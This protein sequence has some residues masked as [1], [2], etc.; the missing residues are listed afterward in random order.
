[1]ATLSFQ[2]KSGNIPDFERPAR[3]ASRSDAGAVYH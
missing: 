3:N 1:V 2:R